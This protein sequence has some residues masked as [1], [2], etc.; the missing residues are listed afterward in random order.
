MTPTAATVTF[1]HTYSKANQRIGQAVSDKTW[2]LYPTAAGTTSYSANAL[3]QYSAVGSVTPSYDGNGNLT[4]DGTFTYAYDAENRLT[5]VKQ[6][7]TTVATYAYDGRG[8]R[9][10]KTVGAT[11]T[12]YVTDADNRE[13]LEY[14]G[15]SGQVGRWY[16]YGLGSNDVLNQMNLSAG[17]RGTFIPDIQGSVM[18]TLD[19]SS[20]ALTKAGYLPFGENA[21]V[22]T[23]TFRFTGQRFDAE[24]AGSAA[25]PSGLYYDRARMY[26]P[27]LGRFMQPDPIGYQGGVHLYAYVGND[28]L[29][30]T[31]PS[32]LWAGLDDA[33]ALGGGAIAGVIGQ[34]AS[35]IF[36][37]RQMSSARSYVAAAAGGAA[38]SEAALYLIPTIGGVGAVPAGAIGG[39]VY[40][41]VNGTNLAT[42][43]GD[44]TIGAA[45]GLIPG[46]KP[47]LVRQGLEALASKV[48]NSTVSRLIQ[49]AAPG[50]SQNLTDN[51]ASS[52]IGT[53]MN[54]DPGSSTGGQKLK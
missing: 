22:I 21:S 46:V 24:T 8:R 1:N 50:A 4:F 48:E 35:D 18:A 33:I 23:G 5:S 26:S 10:T 49:G 40:N 15:S 17:T 11:T 36:V 34:A 38:G 52:I 42:L 19:S 31:D 45:T 25:E 54:S 13:V 9:K 43:T 7:S 53:N 32:G 39:I 37:S 12:V 2:L 27:T 47:G 30:L 51:V 20:G 16:A 14:D 6:G 28:P 3:N 29:N 41:V 44:M